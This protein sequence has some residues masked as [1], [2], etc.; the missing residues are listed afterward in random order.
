MSKLQNSSGAMTWL[1]ADFLPQSAIS[2]IQRNIKVHWDLLDNFYEWAERFIALWDVPSEGIWVIS[3]HEDATPLTEYWKANIQPQLY[4]SEK[5]WESIKAN[6]R[7][8]ET[9]GNAMTVRPQLVHLTSSGKVANRQS[10]V[11]SPTERNG[12]QRSLD[13]HGTA[14][15]GNS[16]NVDNGADR[17][18]VSTLQQELSQV[19]R[20]LEESAISSLVTPSVEEKSAQLQHMHEQTSQSNSQIGDENVVLAGGGS[21]QGEYSDSEDEEHSRRRRQRRTSLEK[22]E[23]ERLQVEKG[24]VDAI[25]LLIQIADSLLVSISRQEGL[26]WS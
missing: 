5:R 12:S 17:F 6:R 2:T 8:R 21:C 11:Q 16:D 15:T 23:A 9:N 13:L 7:R 3:L 10:Y 20:D 26:I 19:T 1:V 4:A 25:A 18:D 22:L 24:W 14:E